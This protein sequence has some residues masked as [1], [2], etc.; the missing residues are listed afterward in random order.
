VRGGAGLTDASNGHSEKRMHL[1]PAN[2]PADIRDFESLCREYATSLE[3]LIGVSLAHQGFEEEMRTLPGKYT[4]PA[5]RI[6]L[7][8]DSLDPS[9]AIGC[10][11]LRPLQ[12]LSTPSIRV[13]EMKR[14]FVRPTARGR[15]LG[16][17]LG[18]SI[19]AAAREM[20]YATMKLDTDCTMAAAIATYTRLGFTPCAPYNTDPCAN[21]LWFD[22]DLTNP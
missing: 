2:T 18:E 9:I 15:G 12:E 22:L 6:I 13:C 14:M 8:R 16:I 11:A 20:G 3:P 4:P 17:M 10:V 21:T 1:H 19:V 7:A 5:G